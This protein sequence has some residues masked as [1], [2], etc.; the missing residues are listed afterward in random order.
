MIHEQNGVLGRLASFCV[1]CPQSGMW[2]LA[3]DDLP[4]GVSGMH[5]GNPV[6]RAVLA[7]AAAH[8]PRAGINVA[9]VIGGSQ[10]ARI[11]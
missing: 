9:L 4:Q 8:I 3:D 1:P 7:R 2:N 11:L 10:G 6:R 5:V